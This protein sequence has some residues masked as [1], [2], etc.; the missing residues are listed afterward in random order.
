MLR[1]MATG[2][3]GRRAK[4][5]YVGGPFAAPGNVSY[6]CA[7]GRQAAGWWWDCSDPPQAM[8]PGQ[9]ACR[10]GAVLPLLRASVL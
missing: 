6:D 3:N 10:P 2:K 4:M 5:R 8:Q 9:A 7:V 1:S